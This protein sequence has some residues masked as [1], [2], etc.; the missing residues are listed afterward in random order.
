MNEPI[1]FPPQTWYWLPPD[2]IQPDPEYHT[3]D[4]AG[5]RGPRGVASAPAVFLFGEIVNHKNSHVVPLTREWQ[6]FNADLMS[7]SEYG[8]HW[9]ELDEEQKKH[10]AQA[11]TGT[12]GDRVAFCNHQGFNDDDN[13]RAN[14]VKQKDLSAELPAYDACRRCATDSV[15]GVVV[16]NS[17]GKKMLLVSSFNWYEGPPENYDIEI[18]GDSRVAWATIIYRKGVVHK[19]PRLK[20]DVPYAFV[21][22]ELVYYPV[23]YLHKYT[24]AKRQL[25]YPHLTD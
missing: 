5:N 3:Y 11:F 22:R 7:L 16:G 2:H 19:F 25:Y 12:F 14:F 24:G 10:I 9:W 21:T 15:T 20:N 13:P 18:L 8:I 1:P 6:E 4:E 17:S 23:E